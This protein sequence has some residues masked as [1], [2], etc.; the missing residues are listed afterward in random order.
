MRPE[1][2]WKNF[3][4]GTELQIAGAYIYN[5]LNVFDKMRSLY[6]EEECFEF[7]YNASV[8]I[9]RL[10]KILLILLEKVEP[11]AQP[12]FEDSLITHNHVHLMDRISALIKIKPNG[13]HVKFLSVLTEFYSYTR[14]SR[15]RMVSAYEEG[16]DRRA[17]IKFLQE[18]LNV[19]IDNES[20]MPT[21]LDKRMKNYVFNLIG[22]IASLY[23]EA[24]EN[25]AR[26][27]NIFTY[28]LTSGSKA[29]KIFRCKEYNFEK[30]RLLKR[31]LLNFLFHI[32]EKDGLIK[33]IR[34]IQPLPFDIPNPDDI[35]KTLIY[36]R[37]DHFM[38]DEMEYLYGENVF[39]KE[40]YDAI[41]IL[42][43]GYYF[44]ET[45]EI[46]EGNDEPLPQ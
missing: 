16:H 3:R 43:E 45:N 39:D 13:P 2:N 26:M 32:D 46:L 25:E 9:E 41:C 19:I 6:Y 35:V 28:E 30:E 1:Y 31:E 12:E 27:H 37:I 18:E 23:Y 5:A 42:G 36:D 21:L 15:Y 7:L 20:L 17:I 11:D 24:I 40:R 44:G 8:G 29:Y 14:Y 34:E 22:K 10:Q 33:L 4:L 38:M